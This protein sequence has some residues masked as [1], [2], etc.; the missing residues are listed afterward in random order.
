[1]R[2]Q[3]HHRPGVVLLT[4]LIVLAVLLLVG[5]QY[6]NLMTAESSASVVSGKV[7]QARYLADSGV[8]YA[9][10]V[11]AYP[12][13]AG[14]SDSDDSYRIWPGYV[15]DNT[16]LFQARPIN[17]PNGIKG[18]FSIVSRRDP[19][20]D[21]NSSTSGYRFGMEDENAKINLNAIRKLLNDPANASLASTITNML[22]NIP[23][24]DSDKANAVVNWTQTGGTPDSSEQSYYSSLNYNCKAGP[25]DTTEE[26]LLV[27]GWTPRL[28]Y[29]N[30]RNR[31][32]T[33]EPDEDD[34]T[35]QIDFG[36]QKY[37]TSYSREMNI[38]STGQPRINI[39]DSNLQNLKTQLDSAFG[40][41]NITTFILLARTTALENLATPIPAPP[42]EPLA[43]LRGFGRT[44][45]N[46]TITNP[47]LLNGSVKIASLWDLIDK[48]KRIE[49][50]PGPAGTLTATSPFLSADPNALRPILSTLFDKFSLTGDS[51][52]PAR[53]NINTVPVDLLTAMGMNSTDVQNIIDHQPSPNTDPSVLTNYR[54]PAWLL[55]EA[56]VSMSTIRALN[57]GGLLDKLF[58]TYSQVYRFQVVG[59]FDQKGPQV[60]LEVV[61]D[62]NNGRPRILHW[63]DL[64]DLGKGYNFS[65]GGS[66]SP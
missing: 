23:N 40:N 53:I 31:N 11:L 26:L 29:G 6:L 20:I 32:G 41:P 13:T 51:E 55:T 42:P 35:G 47:S 18:Y 36:F 45:N 39:N 33:L 62:A 37:F 28:L 4:V 54:T 27:K 56:G 38:D 25:Y 10:F 64:S 9:S 19:A 22:Q 63:R 52:L 66:F 12:Q 59:Y 14:I 34:G 65:Q 1:M 49:S 8:H 7:T 24:F 2:L 58:T 15:Y 50:A 43:G 61:V 46:L 30:D 5:Y 60:R 48:K 3:Q 57:T 44:G 16:D 17:G 21:P